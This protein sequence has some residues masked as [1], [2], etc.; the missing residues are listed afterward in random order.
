MNVPLLA[1]LLDTL[2][3]KRRIRSFS[4]SPE[5]D[6][7]LTTPVPL[8]VLDPEPASLESS[9]PPI[10]SPPIETPEPNPSTNID[11]SPSS[12][13]LDPNPV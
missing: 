6:A 12:L 13:I 11:N 10:T 2:M 8:P 3:A 1:Y 7:P 4:S 9:L 5:H